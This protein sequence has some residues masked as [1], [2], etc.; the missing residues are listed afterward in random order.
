MNAK[1]L[2][3]AGLLVFVAAAII[4]IVVRERGSE[5]SPDAAA[6]PPANAPLPAEGLIA[7]YFHGEIRCPTCKKIESYA[8][9]AIQAGF[10]EE[11]NSAK[12]TW[13]VLNYEVPANAHFATEYEIAAPTIVL[14]HA[15]KG[16][17]EDWRNLTRV[18]EL[19][20]DKDAFVK[21]V[22]EQTRE[23]LTKV[24]S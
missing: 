3:T 15:A 7:Y 9:E 18:W 17:P 5:D 12:L 11:L 1:N 24:E 10:S 2:L 20:G 19:V 22:Q 8:H 4:T 23:L 13:R 16:K 14:V 21:Y 6:G